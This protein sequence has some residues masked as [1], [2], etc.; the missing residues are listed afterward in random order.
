MHKP[1][2][3]N[4]RHPSANGEFCRSNIGNVCLH[5]FSHEYRAGRTPNP[6]IL[7]NKEI[8]FKAFLDYAKQR[9]A[10]YIATG[11]YVA[12]AQIHNYVYLKASIR[13]KIKVIFYM[14]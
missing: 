8:K 1:F 11:H 13:Q 9:G 3:I 6:D 5:I 7:C 10:D 12:L 2:A 14:R 4:L